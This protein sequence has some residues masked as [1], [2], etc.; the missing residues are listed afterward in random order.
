MAIATVAHQEIHVGSSV[1]IE[2]SAPDRRYKVVFEDDGET[3]YFYAVDPAKVSQPIQDAVQ[4][5]NVKSVADRQH[6]SVVE[7]VWSSDNLKAEL[8]INKQ[9]HAV[10]DFSAKQ[11]YCLSGFPPSHSGWSKAGHAWSSQ[12]SDLIK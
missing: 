1:V 7:I 6:P 3:G 9:P 8:L 12:V 5:Y 2:A 11:G 4:I 10:F